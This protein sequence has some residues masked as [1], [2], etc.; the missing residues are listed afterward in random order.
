MLDRRTRGWMSWLRAR[1]Y[2]EGGSEGGSLVYQSPLAQPRQPQCWHSTTL[3]SS[4][5]SLGTRH[6]HT[7]PNEW[8]LVWMHRRQ[9]S[10]SYPGWCREHTPRQ[11]TRQRANEHA[12]RSTY[13]LPLGNQVRVGDALAQAVVVQLTRDGLAAKVELV[14]V[15]AALVVDAED[16]PHGLSLALAFVR[17]VLGCVTRKSEQRRALLVSHSHTL[18]HTYKQAEAR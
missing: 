13:L 8:S 5:L 17:L 10:L 12:A 18:T 11:L 15:A 1:L 16:R 2:R 4:S 14:D 9:Q 6:T 3:P 7:V